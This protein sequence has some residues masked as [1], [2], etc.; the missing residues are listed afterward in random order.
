M[1]RDT[2]YLDKFANRQA[3]KEKRDAPIFNRSSNRASR[4]RSGVTA[5]VGRGGRARKLRVAV[6]QQIRELF[7]PVPPAEEAT[8]D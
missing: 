2:Y 3:R 6:N 5:T 7:H 4:R 8:E 1:N